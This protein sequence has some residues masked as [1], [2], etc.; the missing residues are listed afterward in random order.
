MNW[1]LNDKLRQPG[2]EIPA[3]TERAFKRLISQGF[4]LS[5]DS[6]YWSPSKCEESAEL[7]SSPELKDFVPDTTAYPVKTEAAYH[8]LMGDYNLYH[9]D[10]TLGNLPIRWTIGAAFHKG[11]TKTWVHKVFFRDEETKV[12]SYGLY[13]TNIGPALFNN[14]PFDYK[15]QSMDRGVDHDDRYK[16]MT[17]ILPQAIPFLKNFVRNLTNNFREVALTQIKLFDAELKSSRDAGGTRRVYRSSKTYKTWFGHHSWQHYVVDRVLAHP[18]FIEAHL[19]HKEW[20]KHLFQQ[21]VGADLEN[22]YQ[23][24]DQLVKAVG[25]PFV[26][27][28]DT[29]ADIEY[30]L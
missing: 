17:S 30:M 24:W 1:D 8:T 13:A 12:N 19:T 28:A 22:E 27:P 4:S 11:Q 6:D 10:A 15:D 20:C 18:E 5:H 26:A 16:D 29:A 21:C 14:K 23:T 3:A 2:V 9:Y 7:L 25:K